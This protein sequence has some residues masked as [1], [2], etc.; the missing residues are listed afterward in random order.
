MEQYLY[1]KIYGLTVKSNRAIEQFS[2]TEY[3]SKPDLTVEFHCKKTE[4]KEQ[5]ETSEEVY[6]SHGVA[7]NGLPFFAVWK[8]SK[9][10][11][12]SLLIRYTSGDGIAYFSADQNGELLIVEY[13]EQISFQDIL[14]YF[15]G[16]VIGCILRLKNKVCLHA[17]VVNIDGN[18]VAFIGEKTAGKSTL[19][20]KFAE[21]GYPILSDDIAVLFENVGS[22]WVQPG[23]P[24]LRLWKNTVESLSGFTEKKLTPVL[25][26]IEKY[27]LPLSEENKAQWIFQNKSI[28]LQKVYF[29]K[30]RNSENIT[31][32]KI[33][34]PV[35]S[36]LK[37][38]Q[39][40]YAEY[41][42]ENELKIKEF[43]LFGA[44][45]NDEK[46]SLLERPDDLNSLADVCN[47]IVED[48]ILPTAS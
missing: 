35:E 48:V 34:N 27:Y 2:K 43:Q 7:S 20:A 10:S 38:K 4:R 3:V 15:S 29:L 18:A 23:Y 11:D 30:E 46:V 14:T 21:L 13:D 31:S 44:L 17:G 45:A 24:R 40:I 5:I 8:T 41:M 42:L 9:Q 25:S 16:P 12:D 19:I 28:P 26:F 1:Y 37:L 32:S 47:M 6:K 36:F 22:F 39:N 33:L